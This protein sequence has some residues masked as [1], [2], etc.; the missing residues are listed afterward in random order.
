MAAQ[1]ARTGHARSGPAASGLADPEEREDVGLRI[2]FYG[3]AVTYSET[4]QARWGASAS[5]SA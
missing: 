1:D 5:P 4:A 3:S 2:V